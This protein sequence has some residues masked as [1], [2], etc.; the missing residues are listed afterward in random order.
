M[1]LELAPRSN[2]S[3]KDF[4][5]RSPRWIQEKALA[6]V[7]EAELATFEHSWRDF[8]GR[9]SQL[10]PGTAGA[11]INRADWIFWLVLAGR[12]FGKTRTGAETVKEWAQNPN[13]RILMIAPVA[14]DVREVMIEGPSGLMSCYPEGMRPSYNPS[15]HL[16]TFP[17]GAIGITR[18][19]DEPERLRGPQ[20][21]KFWADE[22]CAWRFM[23]EA[24]NQIMFGFRLKTT[25]LRGIITTTPKPLKLLKQIKSDASTVVTVGS[26][27][28]NRSNLSDTYYS[29]VIAPYVG[30]RIGRQEIDAEI[31]DDN[32]GALW[33]RTL[34]D[35][36]KIKFTEIRWDL[37]VR[38][39][40]AIDPAVSSG[41]ASAE[42][43]IVVCGLTLSGHVIVIDDV[44]CKESPIGWARA[45]IA[46]FKKYNADLIVGEVNNGGDLVAANIAAVDPNLP[47]RAVRASRGK[48]TRAEPVSNLYEQG[49]VHH[50]GSFPILEDQMCDYIPDSGMP[51]PDRMDA[52]VWGVF[53]LLLDQEETTHRVV[54]DANPPSS[55]F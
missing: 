18:S 27:Y 51:S 48:K 53:E 34:I 10:L 13:E 29:K 46:A 36:Y 37:V 55:W 49:R 8:L 25:N 11:A 50:V 1:S 2:E 39:V 24:W 30:T 21:T 54:L 28:D 44:S 9:P 3:L 40:V 38:I 14:A 45:A 47:F 23:E 15:R 7:P 41:E 52:L 4:L 20:F 5:K 22:L 35:A 16:V 12:G 42:T 6:L 43:G 26:S 32:P 31:L 17:S 33:T 19:A